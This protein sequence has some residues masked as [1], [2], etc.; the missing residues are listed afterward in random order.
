[1]N[2]EVDELQQIAQ[3]LDI[4][5]DEHG[6]STALDVAA[7]AIADELAERDKIVS[8]ISI[9]REYIVDVKHKRDENSF[10]IFKE[11]SEYITNN[12][13]DYIDEDYEVVQHGIDV[14]PDVEV[15]S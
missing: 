13:L 5:M 3:R 2:I 11:A 1:M 12:T 7:D 15:D 9:T 14:Y 6:N 10:E 4:F 8:R